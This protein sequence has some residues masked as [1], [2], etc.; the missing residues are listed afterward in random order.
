M[1]MIWLEQ[2]VLR[3]RRNVSEVHRRSQ[4]YIPFSG[5]IDAPR[6]KENSRFRKLTRDHGGRN[7]N[8]DQ[9]NRIILVIRG[10]VCLTVHDTKLSSLSIYCLYMRSDLG[11][12]L[13]N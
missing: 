10:Q 6:R 11:L 9:A 2:N 13:G 3:R 7:N 1:A 4:R 5:R 12:L 8:F